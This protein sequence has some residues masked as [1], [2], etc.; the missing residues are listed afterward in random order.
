MLPFGYGVKSHLCR[1]MLLLIQAQV[2]CVNPRYSPN[3]ILRSLYIISNGLMRSLVKGLQ[4]HNYLDFNSEGLNYVC[5]VIVH[6]ASCERF[7]L[8]M[9]FQFL[10]AHFSEEIIW[11]RSKFGSNFRRFI[12]LSANINFTCVRATRIFLQ[13]LFKRLNF[14]RSDRPGTHFLRYYLFP[15]QL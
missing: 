9:D 5:L 3:K 10:V 4:S 11:T 6:V 14:S 2:F 7:K 13:N 12:L 1:D 8:S 15:M